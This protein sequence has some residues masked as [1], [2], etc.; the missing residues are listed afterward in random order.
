MQINHISINV[1]NLD[2]SVEF[3][4]DT[5]GLEIVD[6]FDHEDMSIVFMKGNGE[7]V[8]EL[9]YHKQSESSSRLQHIGFVVEDIEREYKSISTKGFKFTK[10]PYESRSGVKI[11]FL[12]DPDGIELELVQRHD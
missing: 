9:V 1:K 4:S 3:Y 10:P 11:A 8:I 2:K 12:C 7:G 6:R 5:L